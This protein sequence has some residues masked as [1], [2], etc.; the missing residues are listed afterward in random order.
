M[1]P[2]MKLKLRKIT[3]KQTNKQQRET[4]RENKQACS[5]GT[6][7]SGLWTK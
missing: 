1:L 4:Q 3:Q 7:A 6:L 5:T 2:R